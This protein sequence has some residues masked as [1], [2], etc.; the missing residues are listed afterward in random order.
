MANHIADIA[1]WFFVASLVVGVVSTVL[2]IWMAGVKEAYWEKD[3]T[4][5]AER[6][7]SLTVQGDQLRKDTAEANARAAEAKLALE[8]FKAPRSLKQPKSVVEKL[9]PFA[10]MPFDVALNIEPEV[11]SLMDQITLSLREA[12]W[13]WRNLADTNGI[14]FGR[15]DLPTMGIIA[16]SGVLIQIAESKRQEW[17]PAVHA[18]GNALTA[19]G[20]EV[21]GE[22]GVISDDAIHIKI[23]KKP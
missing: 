11:I 19:E 7:V 17:G 10:G 6:V 20:I 2:I 9:K 14:Q 4:E 3:R 18:L 16:V 5:S 1:N 8:K 15:T 22:V 21:K 23:G 12:G 13:V